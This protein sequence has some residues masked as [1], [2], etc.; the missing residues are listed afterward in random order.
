MNSAFV[1]VVLGMVL[2]FGVLAALVSV[3]T[4][5]VTRFLGLRGEYLLRGLRT[6]VTRGSTFKTSMFDPST[7]KSDKKGGNQSEVL[8]AFLMHPLVQANGDHGTFE[9]DAGNKPLSRAERRCLPAYL[10]ARTFSIALADAV[11]PDASGTTTIDD[12]KRGVERD[13]V[14]ERLR[15]MVLRLLDHADDQMSTFRALLEQWYDNHMARVSG[16]YKRHVRWISLGIAVAFVLV[17][18]LGAV[19]VGTALY[20]DEPLRAAVLEQASTAA[21]CDPGK[22]EDCLAR[23]HE[24]VA[25]LEGMGLPIGW[26]ATTACPPDA[27]CPWWDEY[28]FTE[29]GRDPLH[30]ALHL[31]LVVLG[32]AVM[33]VATVPGARF[34]F[35]ALSRLNSLRETGPKPPA[36]ADVPAP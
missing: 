19:R 33:V 20:L 24:V 22:A 25:P 8:R 17:F 18:N 2:V 29:P 3:V 26:T 16:W 35:D 15:V 28:G 4:E 23:A 7:S 27:G 36:P 31:A 11:V 14:D 1:G 12:I 9:P 21:P 6:I 10:S 13:I 34:W 5:A 32:Y 30:N